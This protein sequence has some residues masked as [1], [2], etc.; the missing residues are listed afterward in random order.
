[1]FAELLDERIILGIIFFR[2]LAVQIAKA[3]IVHLGNGV[4]R[5]GKA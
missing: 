4:R 5:I 3:E 2:Q 1:M